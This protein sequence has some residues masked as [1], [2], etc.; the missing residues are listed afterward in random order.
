ME[1]ITCYVSR[2]DF[3]NYLKVYSKSLLD[4]VTSDIYYLIR[5][6]NPFLQKVN[7]KNMR[8]TTPNVSRG[9][10]KGVQNSFEVFEEVKIRNN[11]KRPVN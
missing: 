2:Q 6:N 4:L 7:N 9:C 1:K 5:H 10:N 11:F 8:Y 3:F